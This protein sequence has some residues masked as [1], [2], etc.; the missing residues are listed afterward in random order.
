M[1]AAIQVDVHLAE[2]GV[3]HIRLDGE[4]DDR[5]QFSGIA[6]NASGA[7]L[8]IDGAGVHRIN[9]LSV[10]RWVAWMTSLES[11]NNRIFLIRA[12][13]ALLLQCYYVVGFLGQQGI[14]ASIHVPFDCAR[15]AHTEWVH[16]VLSDLNPDDPLPTSACPRC[17]ATLSANEIED[18]LVNALRN[19]PTQPLLPEVRAALRRPR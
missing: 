9:S 15:C 5:T 8:V 14:L 16:L 13:R 19:L 1:S 18:P 7:V 17:G 12:S 6:S 3:W 2:D 10:A 4:A 11:R